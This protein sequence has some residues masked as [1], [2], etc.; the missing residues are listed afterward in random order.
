ML[1]VQLKDYLKA[2]LSEEERIVR[3]NIM[4][5]EHSRWV[6]QKAFIE[7]ML[8]LPLT[9]F[10]VNSTKSQCDKT[11]GHNDTRHACIVSNNDL[12]MFE[13]FLLYAAKEGENKVMNY[14][15][16]HDCALKLIY[17]NDL[18]ALASAVVFSKK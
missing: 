15:G 11:K 1:Q 2:N 5:M 4:R 16:M 6:L 13:G 3:D 18:D 10:L 17:D 9:T 7:K 8:P 14:K 12:R